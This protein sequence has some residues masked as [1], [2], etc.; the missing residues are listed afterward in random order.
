MNTLL[1]VAVVFA[2]S[3]AL[4][5]CSA[6][7]LNG[8]PTGSAPAD[9]GHYLKPQDS[10]GGIGTR[11]SLGGLLTVN[12]LD[13]PPKLKKATLEHLNLAVT[14]IDAIKGGQA[15]TIATYDSPHM[16]DVLAHQDGNGE[17]IAKTQSDKVQYDGLRIVVDPTRSN[18]QTAHKTYA[19]SFI[20][21]ATQST[22]GAGLQTTTGQ[23]SANAISM[24]TMQAFA[25]SGDGKT[26]VDMDFNA[27][28]SLGEVH[29]DSVVTR[30]TMFLSSQDDDIRIKGAIVNAFNAA[31]Q[32]ATVVA[33]DSNGN[34]ANTVWTGK[35]GKFSLH[36]LAPGTYHLLVFNVYENAAG[37]MYSADN[38]T[39]SLGNGVN[40]NVPVDGGTISV[41]P[42]KTYNRGTI[43]D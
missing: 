2:F 21:A 35:D 30:P 13:A 22:V 11:L 3:A 9:R 33:V 27:Y 12:L 26:S 15:I 6:H 40:S 42:G 32:G 29:G 41:D 14:R 24:T 5:A 19:L 37:T 7:G 8:T 28:E 16:V 36:T 1:R 43:T 23:E 38:N 4:A 17:P 34:V 39:A 31:V 10:I 20:N 25:V 18:A